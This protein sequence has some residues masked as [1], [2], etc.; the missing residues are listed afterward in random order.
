[1]VQI[2]ADSKANELKEIR[3]LLYRCIHWEGLRK[4]EITQCRNCQSF[5]H[6]ASNCYL[7]RRCVK[8]KDHHEIG[9][10]SLQEVPVNEREKLFC[11][12]CN[13]YG[14]PASYKGC[15]KY[16][17]LQQKLR[18]KKQHLS[19]KRTKN[20]PIIVN[21]NLSYANM[22]KNN[23]TT[24]S[25]NTNSTINSILEQ[26]N[27]SIQALSNQIINLNKQL[28]LQS[29]NS[30]MGGGTA[31]LIRRGIKYSYYNNRKILAFKHL[32]TSVVKIPIFPNKT[33]FII[34]AYYPSGN[35]CSS[36]KSDLLKL[37]QSLNLE[38]T[39]NYYIL[40]GD[41]NCKNTVWNNPIS[42]TKGNYLKEWIED[43]EIRYRCKLYATCNPSYPRCN[44]YLD[45]CIVD[46]RLTIYKVNDSINCLETLDYDSDH[47]TVKIK[48]L[49]VENDH[50]LSFFNEFTESKFNYRKTNWKKFRNILM[51]NNLMN[52]IPADRNLNNNEI[53]YHLLEL[54][55]HITRAIDTTVPKFKPQDSIKR[56]TN[57]II[58][59]LQGE[60]SR[61]VTLI[62]RY[63]RLETF[64]TQSEFNILKA[65]LKLIRKL[66]NDNFTI[67]VNK[68]IQ[69]R[70][71]K[72]RPN[73]SVNMFGEVRK[74]F[75]TLQ[76]YE[77]GIMKIPLND[78]RLIRN[79][80]IDPMDLEKEDGNANYLIQEDIHS[81]KEIDPY[82]HV[83][84]E[85]NHCFTEFLEEKNHYEYND[86]TMTTFSTSKKADDLKESQL[87]NFFISKDKVLSIFR[88]LRP[89]LSSGVDNIPNVVLRNL[90]D[91]LISNYGILFNNMLNNAYFPRAWKQAKVIILPKKDKDTTNPKNLRAISLLPNISKVFEVFI[92]INIIKICDN[93]NLISDRQFGFKYKHSTIHAIHLLVSNIQWNL[94]K[95]LYTGACLVDFEKAFDNVWIPGLICKLLKFKF[96]PHLIIL[97]HNMLN[98]RT[99]SVYGKESTGTR[100][101]TIVNGLQQGTVNSPILFNLYLL[102]LIEKMENIIAFADDITI[103]HADNTVDKI[104]DGLQ[105]KFFLIENYSRNWH[106]KINLNKCECILFRPPVGKCNSNIRKYWK[107][108]GIKSYDNICIPVKQTV[109]LLGIYLDKFLYFNSHI[110]HQ[111][112][113]A[114]KA[115]VIYKKLF[116]S[117]YIQSRVKTIMYQSLIRPILSYG[118][119]IWFNI[120]PSYMEKIRIFERKC[121]RCCTSLYRSENSDYKKYISNKILYENAEIS[122]FDNFIIHII[123]DHIIKSVN[124]TEN[125]L[126]MAPYYVSEEYIARTLQNGFIPPEAF[127]F[128]DRNGFIQNEDGIP[129]FYHIYRRSN[130]KSI[131]CNELTIENCRFDTNIYMKDKNIK[132]NLNIKKYWWLTQ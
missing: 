7:P 114:R 99:F 18:A 107:S 77:L 40:A 65:K 112:T 94:N 46:S 69:D 48:L 85:V 123:R 2:N 56:Y 73:D 29:K 9:K 119:Q 78:E 19:D 129:V 101:F 43:Y 70:L 95:S 75:R 64:L 121:L 63:N 72:M 127:L 89:K 122:R 76:T 14:H 116:F 35:N 96:P 10:C 84:L 104:N 66:I 68:N 44:S 15:S 71:S 106:M 24:Q 41:L 115:F 92:N 59:K 39:E 87:N 105:N 103:Y 51:N 125:N 50:P 12:L 13:S 26:L 74:Q 6:S 22:V 109:K 79:T 57:S 4:P 5:L 38:N 49:G 67:S 120:C 28:Q 23:F 97:I 90:P 45:L 61:I 60:K 1:M 53:D 11:V 108:F 8:C 88:K 62:K 42:N 27:N 132:P 128:L 80:G 100:K 55:N 21:D 37:F 131:I 31:I 32:E 83:H 110:K 93:K 98:N 102:D 91:N 54:N 25:A 130:I 36:F 34:A 126:I 82:N 117:K 17:E 16:K 3:G 58:R 47:E 118:C 111:L 124:T 113:K 20:S 30:K 86:K 52:L 81:F 33:L